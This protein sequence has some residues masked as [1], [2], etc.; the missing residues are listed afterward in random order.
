MYEFILGD[1]TGARIQTLP[2]VSDF[3]AVLATNNVSRFRLT[4]P[5]KFVPL[6]QRN[7]IIE[8]WRNRRLLIAGL[9]RTWEKD[10]QTVTI[11]CP[12]FNYLLDGRIVAYAAGSSEAS[13]AGTADDVIKAIVRENLGSSA[14]AA[15]QFNITVQPDSSAGQ[16]IDHSFAWRDVLLVAQDLALESA[17]LGSR[18]YFGF[19]VYTGASLSLVFETTTGQWGADRSFDGNSPVVFS[20]GFGNLK[21]Y[22][23]TY[24]YWDEVN[25]TYIGGQ[26]LGADRLVAEVSN[27]NSLNM[28]QWSRRERF[29]NHC[30][31]ISNDALEDAGKA[32]LYEWRG[33]ETFSA[34]LVDIPS[35]RFGE[36][37]NWGD[38]VAI[39]QN[40]KQLDGI[41]DKVSIQLKQGKENLQ[42]MVGGNL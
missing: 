17:Q 19:Q 29:A 40:G 38:R 7:Q 25:Y 24:D 14:P 22:R 21:N 23:E 30:N 9:V 1:S 37:W 28:D 39:V 33:K 4:I 16:T 10:D 3:T 13:K 8:V 35:T 26:G 6:I 32:A 18:V 11:T 42:V 2:D 5:V 15:R 41:I 36:H 12:D 27:S 20:T 34:Q 31:A